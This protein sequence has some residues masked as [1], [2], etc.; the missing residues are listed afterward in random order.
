M[1]HRA[2]LIAEAFAE[3]G[4]G[5]VVVLGATFA[6][7]LLLALVLGEAGAAQSKV[8]AET[9]ALSGS[10]VYI[11]NNT[12]ASGGKEVAFYT[13]GS[14]SSSFE[15]AAASITLHSRG[16]ACQG[17]PR[18][19]IYVDGTLQGRVDLTSST[20]A[21]YP[22]AL[23]GLSAGTHTLRISFANDYYISSTCDR[24]VDLDYYEV[25]VPDTTPTACGKGQFLAEYRNELRT[26][27]TCP[28]LARCEAAIDND[29]GS[30]SPDPAAR[31][32]SFTAR[33]VGTFDFEASDY[34]FTATADDGVRLWVDGRLLIDQWKDQGAT[35][36]RAT[37]NMTAGAHQ[38]K[39]EYYEYGGLAVAR[40]SWAKVASPLPLAA[41]TRCWSGRGT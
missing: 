7:A 30:G 14:A 35:T 36:Y 4:R 20:Y 23:S 21:D 19:R 27:I 11:E 18:L 13:N 39:V 15:G 40:S 32:D 3:P 22:L 1:R 12:A 38:V 25:T 29:W 24:N 9:M 41:R 26:F 2:G 5:I 16:T 28:V 34:E 37:T 8:E 10:H 33:W 6:V 31:P 17:N